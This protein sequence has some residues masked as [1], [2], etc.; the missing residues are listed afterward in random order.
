M[1][2]EYTLITMSAGMSM[3]AWKKAGLISRENGYYAKLSGHV[4]QLGFLTY[5]SFSEEKECLCKYIPTGR[6]VWSMPA[7][8]DKIRYGAFIASCLAPIFK[9]NFKNCKLIRSNQMSGAWTGAI[10][11]KR[12]KIPFILRCG[13]IFSEHYTKEH[14][15][16][17]IR[18]LFF[19]LLERW[20]AKSADEIIVTYTGAK[21]FFVKEHNIPENKIHVLGNPVDTNLFKPILIEKDRRDIIS[22]GRFTEQKNF[23]SLITACAIAKVNLTLLGS[24]ILKESLKTFA[25]ENNVDVC[26]HRRIQNE[27]IPELFAKHR[28][29]VLPSLYEGNPKALIEAMSCGLPCIASKIPEH[30]GL[31]NDGKEGLLCGHSAEEIAVS[32]QKI[33]SIPDFAAKIGIKARER[34]VS[35]Y[36]CDVIAKREAKIH[37]LAAF[38]KMD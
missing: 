16:N 28:M 7:L 30:L 5:G 37:A 32:I 31:I 3:V 33:R 10:I 26:F 29:F 9:L 23:Y 2:D 36:S 4:G 6:I 22:V 27:E 17:K 24:G 38:E 13:Y 1:S 14:E 11:A 19:L 18:R 15:N 20:V 35:E 25:D 21:D 12:F 8:F 34:I